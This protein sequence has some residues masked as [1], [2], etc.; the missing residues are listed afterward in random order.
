MRTF[1]KRGRLAA[2]AAAVAA[3]ALGVAGM[4][5]PPAAASPATTPSGSYNGLALTPPMGFNDWAKYECN[6]N[7]NLFMKT[8]DA[9]VA[10]GLSKLGYTYVNVDDCWMQKTRDANGNLQVDTALFPQGMKALGDHLH[11]E[12]LK[13]GIYEDAGTNTCQGAAGSYGHFDQDARQYASWGVDYLKLDYCYQPLSDY[14]GAS[15][16]D[17]AKIVYTQA[18]EA[19][20]KTGRP[21]VFSESAP[22]YYFDNSTFWQIMKWIGNEGNLWRVGD[23]IADNWQ[24]VLTNYEQTSMLRLAP[25][26][27]PGHWND[28]DML[29]VGNP[30]LSLTEQQSQFTLWSELASPLLLST[31]VG[32]LSGA[33][34]AIVSNKDVIA[35]DQDKLGAQGT[36][37]QTG[38]GYDVLSKP[39]ANGDRAVVLFNKNDRAQTITTHA[40]T[41]GFSGTG[42][43]TLKDLVSKKVTTSTGTIA[44]TVPPHGTVIYRVSPTHG[45][46]APSATVLSVTQRSFPGGKSVSVPVSLSDDGPNPLNGASVS[47]HAPA[48]WRVEPSS[49][50]LGKVGAGGSATAAFTVIAPAPPPGRSTDTLT[51]TAGYAS[52]G[53]QQNTSADSTV[54]YDLPYDNLAQAFN[55]AAVTDESAPTAGDFD[56]NGDTYSAQA[57]AKAGVTP[58][59]TVTANGL[60]FTWPSAASGTPDNVAGGAV[61]IKESGSGS[62]LALL[63]AEAGFDSATVT[64][65]YTDG[66]TSTGTLGF[67]NW[68]CSP[69]DAY[70]AKVAIIT[71]HRDTP[72]GPAN[73]GTD[74]D[75][76]SNTI[77]LTAGKQIATVT[78]PGDSAIH[79]FAIS[80]M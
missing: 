63:G 35:V 79:I 78:L 9:L 49:V 37:V 29:E 50:P 71:D 66:T 36:V 53:R 55:N 18:S 13:F 48:G 40:T 70:G 43:V 28:A 30:G 45:A 52:L 44:A 41:V 10:K 23:D 2:V 11:A 7:E 27:G 25:Y 5:G 51:A 24:S 75:V 73:F 68:C 14:P 8:G 26:A 69:T 19:L 64:V 15:A 3:V 33:P 1:R 21:I 4:S 6:I 54:L 12:G 17:V 38:G 16:A 77:P 76:F 42:N 62:E 57:L 34:L 39:L 56:G 47:L 20:R 72:S 46:S 80:V 32:A 59:S 74:Y 65:K 61:T 60:T 22:A 31:D 58:G 67:P